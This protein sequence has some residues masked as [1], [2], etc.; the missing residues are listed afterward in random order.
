[1][2]LAAKLRLLYV[3]VLIAIVLAI[4][5]GL[6]W[7]SAGQA[8]EPLGDA[9]ISILKVMI[10]PIVFCTVVLGLA[11]LRDL[12][13]LGR[14]VLKALVYFEVVSTFSLALGLIVGNVFKPGAGMHAGTEVTG[15]VHEYQ[16]EAQ[17][18]GG[19]VEFLQGLIPKTFVSAFSEGEIL[20][21][22]IISVVFGVAML[23][24]MDR[25]PTLLKLIEEAQK[26]FFKML[27]FVMRLA[28]FGA[29][30]A[31]ASTVGTYGGDTLLS[32]LY[33]VLLVY[34]TA[35]V[36]VLVVLGAIC[37]YCRI[38]IFK[39]LR[40]IREEI[41]LVLGTSSSEVAL[42]RL[43]EKLERA[44]CPRSTV[45]IVLPA[46]YAFN[47]DGT[48]IYMSMAVVFI[49]QATD[50]PLSLG[51]QLA[52]LAVML[53]TSKGG[54]GVSGLGFVKLAATLQS[55][56]AL[57]MGGLGVLIGVDR[58]MSEARSITNVIGNSVATIAVSRWE[59]T[60]DQEKFEAYYRDPVVGDTAAEPEPEPD[61]VSS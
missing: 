56:P 29:F 36:F 39:V 32:L 51:Q 47:M 1:M 61:R 50:A 53:F 34:A 15:K 24:L 55:V 37:A 27:G 16:Q 48:A 19:I 20:Q 60:F 33:L 38:S 18:S 23:L 30:G 42:P 49:S 26:V 41:I 25:V 4:I 31:M 43:L 44:G 35:A 10:G 2:K 12:S 58:F 17:Q 22:L 5:L 28:P 52:V 40:L 21:V 14:V 8:L 6:V 3:Q 7:P 57:P 9:F 11:Q 46:G 13:K 54:A 45:G 59:N